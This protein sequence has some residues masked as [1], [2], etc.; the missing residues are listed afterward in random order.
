MFSDRPS[1]HSDQIKRGLSNLLAAGI[2][3]EDSRR[4]DA[5]GALYSVVRLVDDLAD[6]IIDTP[7]M[8]IEQRTRVLSEIQRLRESIDFC[9]AGNSNTSRFDLKLA[10][11]IGRFQIP[12]SLW[13]DLFTAI[14]RNVSADGFVSFSDM[15]TYCKGTSVVPMAMFLRVIFSEPSKEGRFQIDDEPA[16]L[17][18]S[19]SLGSWGFIIHSLAVTRKY[20]TL[21]HAP[22]SFLPI[23]LV[24]EFGLTPNDMRL[25]ALSGHSD[26]RTRKL[27][28]KY[29]G[30]ARGK[31]RTGFEYARSKLHHLSPDR[32]IALVSYLA[33]YVEI[34]R[35][36][37]ER[38]YEILGEIPLWNATDRSEL[39]ARISNS[40]ALESFLDFT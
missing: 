1:V 18:A 23:D 29:L 5:F 6:S 37:R 19:E 26:S 17:R 22:R 35:R 31:G 33:V 8:S 13:N 3:F 21:P 2:H 34:M 28:E 9:Y 16:L 4:I 10:H 36:I 27:V 38:S 24:T 12:Q 7:D 20:F 32:Q 15:L 39:T 40:T 25:Q 14:N 11:A 30:L